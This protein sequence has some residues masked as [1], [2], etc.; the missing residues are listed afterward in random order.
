MAITSVF[1]I[2]SVLA[3]INSTISDQEASVVSLTQKVGDN[4]AIFG[5]I[6]D[7]ASKFQS[8]ISGVLAE[9]QTATAGVVASVKTTLESIKSVF[10]EV[11][12]FFNSIKNTFTSIADGVKIKIL[13][14]FNVFLDK[15]NTIKD[16]IA[17]KMSAITDAM[18]DMLSNFT[19]NLKQFNR[20]KCSTVAAALPTSA[21]V[22]GIADSL[23][24]QANSAINS[25]TQSVESVIPKFDISIPTDIFA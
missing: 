7:F 10:G 2:E 13:A 5:S 1:D 9:I 16:V 17:A 3:T 18:S 15:F 24:N 19:S 21:T 14:F 4:C 25:V 20:S 12:T 8:D 22:D 23:K 11:N 6:G